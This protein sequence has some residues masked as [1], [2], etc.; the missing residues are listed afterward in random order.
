M[1]RENEARN[2]LRDSS[3]IF[4]DRGEYKNCLDVMS[5]MI[6]IPF[7][8]SDND[9]LLDRA[10]EK[11]PH[12]LP[13][14]K[15]VKFALKRD[16][17]DSIRV[18]DLLDRAIAPLFREKRNDARLKAI[19][20]DKC[21]ESDLY[22]IKSFLP[23]PVGDCFIEKG[24]FSTA[25]KCFLH[26]DEPRLAEAATEKAI[27]IAKQRPEA[28]S[29]LVDIVNDWAP[30][31][32]AHQAVSGS[33][34][35]LLL[36]LFQSP[37]D[38]S[39]GNAAK[40]VDE[41]GPSILKFAIESTGS[42]RSL[43]YSF[44]RNMFRNDVEYFI[45][46]RSNNRHIEVV[47]WYHARNDKTNCLRYAQKH[48]DDFSKEDLI[49]SIVGRFALRPEGLF[50]E[51]NKRN[52]VLD[53]IV[54]LLEGN[55][56]EFAEQLSNRAL[57]QKSSP[58]ELTNQLRSIWNPI[59][60][61]NRSARLAI[62]GRLSSSSL[63]LLLGLY[64]DPARIARSERLRQ[65]CIDIFGARVVEEAVTLRDYKT[66]PY[67]VLALFNG[68]N[69]SFATPEPK[70]AVGNRVRI[71]GLQTQTAVRLNNVSEICFLLD[72]M[73][74]TLLFMLPWLTQPSCFWPT[75]F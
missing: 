19:L 40:Y 27:A 34:T 49:G 72:S 45:L 68:K 74:S 22:A 61:S 6:D 32:E 59:L 51:L 57:A 35:R 16:N 31:K 38:A 73:D 29:T 10:L 20:R 41:L 69:V 50:D 4:F 70:F 37:G 33:Q 75:L 53:A 42:D 24:K 44:D 56:I 15:M 1:A 25:V 52:A 47:G 48:L 23:L 2:L 71:T 63:S 11:C 8:D 30:Y 17:W 67:S 66:G 39:R 14:L 58:D 26:G 54:T 28:L 46:E 36:S 12:H 21:E 18:A 5:E 60:Q 13:R 64:D 3:R 65:R 7:W 62:Q 55:D 43:L 9:G